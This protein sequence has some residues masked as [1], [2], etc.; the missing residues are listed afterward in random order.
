MIG[1][2]PSDVSTSKTRLWM[3]RVIGALLILFLAFDA[4]VKILNLRVAVQGTT[5]LGY[6]EHLVVVL[7]IVEFIC[8]IAYIV[9]R[10]SVIGAIL[11][12]G[13]LGGATATQVRVGDPW[14]IFPVVVGVLVWV[15]LFLRD[16]R[17]RPLP[18]ETPCSRANRRSGV[19]SAD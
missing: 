16:A 18:D 2:T 11:L 13:Y 6:P 5:G 8:L 1:S 10:T 4:G 15:G 19:C 9:P 12:T 17:L 3:G 14:F 7:G